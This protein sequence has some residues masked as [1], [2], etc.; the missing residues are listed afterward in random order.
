MMTQRLDVVP[1]LTFLMVNQC[2]VCR[3]WYDR[4]HTDRRDRDI[5]DSDQRQRSAIKW[6]SI[7]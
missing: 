1:A 7:E 6:S 2:T 5:S 4:T 3:L